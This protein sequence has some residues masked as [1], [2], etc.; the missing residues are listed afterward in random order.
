MRTISGN[1]WV[2]QGLA[3][4]NCMSALDAHMAPINQLHSANLGWLA[5]HVQPL[6]D[7]LDRMNGKASV[8]QTFADAWQQVSTKVDQIQQRLAHAATKDTARWQGTAADRYRS[9]AAEITAALRHVA[10]VAGATSAAATTMGQAIATG[11]QQAHDQVTD[12]V[13][14]LTSFVAL[15]TAV[16]GGLT[17]NTLAQATA[18]INSYTTPIAG[19]EQQVQQTITNVRPHIN[20]LATATT[21]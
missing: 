14:R 6:Q 2:A 16:N 8:I 7:A 10:A 9:T 21:T 11:R 15:S 4:G 3:A 18:L 12:L 20:N 13:Q 1:G 19:I 17:P 5:G